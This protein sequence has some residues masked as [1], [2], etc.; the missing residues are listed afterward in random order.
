MKKI[1]FTLIFVI[2]SCSPAMAEVL[3]V[4]PLQADV[5][6]EGKWGEV[7]V[8]D[9][10]PK[11]RQVIVTNKGVYLVEKQSVKASIFGKCR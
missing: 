2:R 8:F 9:L 1:L 11:R 3:E 5:K 4:P 10:D 7:R 6:T